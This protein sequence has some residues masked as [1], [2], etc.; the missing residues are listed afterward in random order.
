MKENE[1]G[2]KKLR[3][4]LTK[5]LKKKLIKNYERKKDTWRAIGLK[6]ILLI[7][8]CVW[9]TGCCYAPPPLRDDVNKKTNNNITR[10]NF[11]NI[12]VSPLKIKIYTI[13]IRFEV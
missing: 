1:K 7:K 2:R 6:E 5:K 10:F 3:K 4:K 9:G 11:L 12:I 8:N 13:Y